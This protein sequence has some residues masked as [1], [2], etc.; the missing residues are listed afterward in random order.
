MVP[1][2]PLWNRTGAQGLYPSGMLARTLRPREQP[3]P[4][5]AMAP[6]Q[7]SG[8]CPKLQALKRCETRARAMAPAWPMALAKA[9]V[10]EDMP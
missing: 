10:L 4:E 6:T 2:R 7:G 3:K 8:A 5:H 1:N 9:W